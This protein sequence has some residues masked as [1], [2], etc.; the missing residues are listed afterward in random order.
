MNS[1]TQI[2]YQQ[3]YERNKL[4]RE[5]LIVNKFLDETEKIMLNDFEA[6]HEIKRSVVLEVVGNKSKEFRLIPFS[7]GKR[8]KF[9]KL[10]NKFFDEPDNLSTIGDGI[11]ELE[12]LI[13]KYQ[14]KLPEFDF[15][16]I[17]SDV[18]YRIW[19]NEIISGEWDEFL[20]VDLGFEMARFDDEYKKLLYKDYDNIVLKIKATDPSQLREL[21]Q[22]L[23]VNKIPVNLTNVEHKR[24]VIESKFEAFNDLADR[25]YQNDI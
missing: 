7:N 6:E 4:K 23:F 20:E 17:A 5:F 12:D 10:F 25:I 8:N 22:T 19:L 3:A 15:N 13:E 21:Y 18:I 1:R 2:Q 11:F 9:I 14:Q 16:L 24:E